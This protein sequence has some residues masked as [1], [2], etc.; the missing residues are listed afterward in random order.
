MYAHS[1][2]F[3]FQEGKLQELVRFFRESIA[4]VCRQQE[5]FRGI[6]FFTD[7]INKCTAITLWVSEDDLCNNEDS[8]SY[9]EQLAQM[10]PFLKETPNK[11]YFQVEFYQ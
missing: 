11:E 3:Q 7:K 4:E 8:S 2:E 9:Q 6:F 1:L 5:G 10:Q